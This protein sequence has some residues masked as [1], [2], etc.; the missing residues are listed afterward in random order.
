[1]ALSPGT[2]LGVYEII[3]LRPQGYGGQTAHL[4]SSSCQ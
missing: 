2:K 1:M 3:R 4:L